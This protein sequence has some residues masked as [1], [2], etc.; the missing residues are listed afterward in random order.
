[1]TK[2]GMPEPG[3]T[4]DPII[5][6]LQY[7]YMGVRGTQINNRQYKLQ[8]KFWVEITTEQKETAPKLK[9]KGRPD[10][11]L[12]ISSFGI[13]LCYQPHRILFYLILS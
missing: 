10:A 9:E 4:V 2:E 1:M 6:I 12:D 11:I 3:I 13:F 8:V 7:K 5:G